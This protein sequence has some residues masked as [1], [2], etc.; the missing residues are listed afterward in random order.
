MPEGRE[1]ESPRRS[2]RRK[3]VGG[4]V[5]AVV[6]RAG[7]LGLNFVVM[8][9]VT[10]VLDPTAAGAYLLAQ[11]IANAA[12]LVARLGLENTV[13]FLVSNALGSGS[14]ARALG[15]IRRV[16]ALGVTSAVI[17]ATVLSA[18]GGAWIG[19]KVFGSALVARVGPLL[20]PWTAALALQMLFA[21]SFRGF[22]A[23]REAALLGGVVSGTLTL[24]GLCALGLR[25]PVS[26]EAAVW[27]ATLALTASAA[28]A[29]V[30]LSRRA[31][32]LATAGPAEPISGGAVLREALPVLGSNLTAFV[33][34]NVDVWVVGSYLPEREV[35]TYAAAAR[36]VTLISLGAA[37]GNQVLPPIIGEL[38]ATGERRLME[39]ALRGVAFAVSVPAVAI[40]AVFVLAGP[41][42]L[43]VAFG[44]FY[45]AGAG[46]LR[47]LSIGQVA[48][49][50]TGSTA[51]TLLMTGHQVA[52]LWLTASAA[53]AAA[54]ACLVVVGHGGALGVAEALASVLVV[55]QLGT[56]LVARR[57]VGVWTHAS[58]KAVVAELRRLRARA[59]A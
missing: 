49:V 36:L 43:R 38:H 3:L 4:G 40:A 50:V 29:A 59:G 42:V 16:A 34:L 19:Q 31:R 55:Q 1:L 15:A 45:E 14:P 53:A 48:C 13:V 2:L 28:V 33:I 30:A 11:V 12:A 24:V 57:L 27:N 6:G 41:L 35:A 46:V 44:P 21:E 18:G 58:P 22:H 5:W 37:V 7:A 17:A 54:A 26:L 32:R 9:L 56:L 52:S 51:F 10:R 25:G 8:A 47:V 39:R 23:I 20:G